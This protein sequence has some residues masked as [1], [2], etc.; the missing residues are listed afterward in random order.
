MCYVVLRFYFLSFCGW[1]IFG[2]LKEMYGKVEVDNDDD[3]IFEDE[4]WGFECCWRWIIFDDFNLL[5][6][7]IWGRKVRILS[8]DIFKG[9]DVDLFFGLLDMLFYFFI[10]L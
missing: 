8:G 3:V 2:L 1:K 5:R 7:W 4:D 9:V 6:F 10:G